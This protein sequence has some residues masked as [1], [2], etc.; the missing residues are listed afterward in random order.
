MKKVLSQERIHAIIG[1]NFSN[2][3]GDKK[4]LAKEFGQFLEIFRCVNH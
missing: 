4:K 2:Y 3:T 1:Q